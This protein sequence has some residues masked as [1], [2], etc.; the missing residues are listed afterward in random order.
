[1]GPGQIKIKKFD[2]SRVACLVDTTPEQ[3]V[4]ILRIRN[5]EYFRANGS[6]YRIDGKVGYRMKEEK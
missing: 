5:I 4:T 1:M 3:W 2:T 6:N